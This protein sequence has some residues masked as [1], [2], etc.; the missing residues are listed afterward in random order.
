MIDITKSKFCIG[1]KVMTKTIGPPSIGT[2]FGVLDPETYI[3]SCILSA[4]NADMSNWDKVCPNWRDELIYYI[5]YNEPQRVITI[6][7]YIEH[8][9]KKGYNHTEAEWRAYYLKEVT[10]RLLCCH[11][12]SDLE[13]FE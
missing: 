4:G 1:E 3:T 5:K 13:S 11:P 8:L 7:E 9:E 2:V 12:E 10:P 6:D